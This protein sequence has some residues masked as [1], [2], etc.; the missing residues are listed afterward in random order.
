MSS[1]LPVQGPLNLLCTFEEIWERTFLWSSPSSTMPRLR[2]C[3]LQMR[4]G[5]FF[6]TIFV[7]RWFIPRDALV[8]IA[9]VANRPIV[10]DSETSAGGFVASP[11]FIAESTALL[12]LRVL[13]G[14]MPSTI[15]PATDELK[16]VFD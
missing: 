1:L 2:G 15:P 9:E 8:A 6:N 12:A 5:R 10:V 14:Q 7:T 3:V 13:N 11:T 4:Q 16:P